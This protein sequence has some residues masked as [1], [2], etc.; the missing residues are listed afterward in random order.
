MNIHEQCGDLFCPQDINTD[1]MFNTVNFMILV[2][3]NGIKH[4]IKFTRKHDK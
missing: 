3:P 2:R 4:S 1:Y